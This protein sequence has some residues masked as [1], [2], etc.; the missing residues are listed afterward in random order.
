M[1]LELSLPFRWPQVIWGDDAAMDNSSSKHGQW[2]CPG[3][4]CVGQ[5]GGIIES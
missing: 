5:L 2:G 4:S 1:A 3:L